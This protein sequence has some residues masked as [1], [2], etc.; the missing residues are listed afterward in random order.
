MKPLIPNHTQ[1]LVRTRF[2]FGADTR[3]AEPEFATSMNLEHLLQP[4]CQVPTRKP[5][6]PESCR[7]PIDFLK[8]VYEHILA[9]YP[10][11][12]SKN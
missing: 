6:T 8:E 4:D 10:R 12:E 1:N 11:N 2:C 7:L 3:A 5:I 9:L